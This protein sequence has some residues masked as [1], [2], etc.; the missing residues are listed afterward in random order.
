MGTNNFYKYKGSKSGNEETGFFN[1]K[2]R[3]SRNAYL[4]RLLL[5]LGIYLVSC[6]FVYAEV[7]KEDNAFHQYILPSLLV[8]FLLIQG[9]KRMHD[10]DRTSWAF[11]IPI[12]NVYLSLLPGTPGNNSYGIDPTPSKASQ[13]FDELDPFQKNSS[14]TLIDSVPQVTA[15]QQ[16]TPFRLPV[17]QLLLFM[18]ACLLILGVIFRKDLAD[19]LGI[20]TDDREES[21]VTQGPTDEQK[22]VAPTDITLSSYEVME[23]KSPGTEVG[24]FAA[25]DAEED[26]SNTYALVSG[27]GGTDN[28]SFAISGKSLTTTK[29]FDF[30]SKDRYSIRV[31]VTDGKSKPFERQ[32]TI[33]V[34]DDVKDNRP[35]GGFGTQ[36]GGGTKRTPKDDDPDLFYCKGNGQPIRLDKYQNGVCDCPDKSDELPG[37]CK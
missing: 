17:K 29:R 4:L 18:L 28:G 23:N 9:A 7:Y 31:Q 35:S 24:T 1:T 8:V 32:L 3:I 14:G 6:L 20:E 22:N 15:S 13:Y 34:R 11:L 2:G 27:Q 37:T 25:I 26:N 30:E 33:Q 5:V 16:G 21:T 36:G 19:W 10:V 12:Y